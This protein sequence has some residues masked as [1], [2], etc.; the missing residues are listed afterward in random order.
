MD[1]NFLFLNIDGYADLDGFLDNH[2]LE[3][4]NFHRNR[5]WFRYMDDL[6]YGNW[7][8]LGYL[9]WYG[10][11][12]VNGNR[13][14]LIDGHW[15]VLVY[16][17]TNWYVN[18]VRDRERLGYVNDLRNVHDLRDLL[19]DGDLHWHGDMLGNMHDMRH[20]DKFVHGYG[21]RYGH[22][23]WNRYDLVDVLDDLMDVCMFPSVATCIR[24]SGA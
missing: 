5:N 8:V 3:D 1:F 13:H 17:Y 24:D 19:D 15:Y 21:F 23:L 7:D 14:M 9:Y 10:N 12:L 22:G 16:G 18:Y 2:F 4:G 11:L 20:G 6:M